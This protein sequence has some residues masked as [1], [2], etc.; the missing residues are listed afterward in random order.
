MILF[1]GFPYTTIFF[2]VG[3]SMKSYKLLRTVFYYLF[4]M[5]KISLLGSTFYSSNDLKFSNIFLLQINCYSNHGIPVFYSIL[6]LKSSTNYE[7]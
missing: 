7:G 1:D 6:T 3:V 4:K 2:S 5:R